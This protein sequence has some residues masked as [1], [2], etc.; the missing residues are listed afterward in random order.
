MAT[1]DNN[2]LNESIKELLKIS[3]R[4]DTQVNN[5]ISQQSHTNLRVDKLIE[6]MTQ[7]ETKIQILELKTNNNESR[8]KSIVDTIIKIVGL[9]IAGYIAAHLNIR[10]Q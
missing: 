8:W 9:L 5:L 6:R 7:T 1:I 10:I 3:T 4:I 2:S